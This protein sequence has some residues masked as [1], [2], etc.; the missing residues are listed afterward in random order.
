MG[1]GGKF[2][3]YYSTTLVNEIYVVRRIA[4][5]S[6]LNGQMAEIVREGRAVIL[7]G[8]RALPRVVGRQA[9]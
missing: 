3:T 5:A 1:S 8:V 6:L 2:M 9:G 4:G 7:V